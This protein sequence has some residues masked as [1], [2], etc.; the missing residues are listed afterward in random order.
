MVFKFRALSGEV[1]NFA[2][3]YEI[4][5]QNTLFELHQLIQSDLA[6]DASQMASFFL[7][8][9]GWNKLREFTLFDLGEEADD[10]EDAPVAMDVV[11]LK[12][13]V[14]EK[15]QRLLY[16]FDIFNDRSLFF[17]VLEHK[18]AEEGV[19][20]PIVTYS[21]GDAPFQIEIP[22]NEGSVYDDVMEDFNEF[23]SY[24]EY[25]ERSDDEF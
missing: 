13:V 25:N 16:T 5:D 8:D 21:M 15:N 19:K 9:H 7:V 11:T 4:S 10:M 2:R 17:E 23:E 6:Y 18:K 22:K 3:D 1:E 12:E 24:E 20:Y 14:K